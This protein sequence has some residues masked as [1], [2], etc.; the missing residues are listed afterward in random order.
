MGLT[1][2]HSLLD[3]RA[4]RS[5]NAVTNE[6]IVQ[7]A[8]SC[9]NLH[10]VVLNKMPFLKDQVLAAFFKNCPNLKA[11]EMYP[12][13]KKPEIGLAGEVFDLLRERPDWVPKLKKLTV[14][15]SDGIRLTDAVRALTK[16]R[17][18]LVAQ[19]ASEPYW[20][21][22]SITFEYRKGHKRDSLADSHEYSYYSS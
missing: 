16:E 17:E 22:S 20:G 3:F 1:V 5:V 11:L 2:C 4:E 13:S 9:P 6:V 14:A 18:K 19:L 7:F 12:P 8:A 10:H 21:F 15:Y